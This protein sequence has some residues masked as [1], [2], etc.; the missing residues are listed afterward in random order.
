MAEAL[1]YRLSGRDGAPGLVLLH[2]LG[3]TGDLWWPQLGA[4][5]ARFRVI[6]VDL[7][8]HGGSPMP[9]RGASVS[10]FT[11]MIAALI[12]DAAPSGA[13]VAGISTGGMIAQSLAI[14]HPSLVRSLALCNTTSV[15]PQTPP[16]TADPSLFVS[17]TLVIGAA[18]R[19]RATGMATIAPIAIQRWFRPAFQ[20]REPASVARVEQMI[21][22]NQPE[23]YA[24]VCEAISRF[25]VRARLGEIR[26]PTLVIAGSHDPGTPLA[27]SLDLVASIPSA[28][29]VVI[30][31][32]AHIS[33]VERPAEFTAALTEFLD[34]RA[35]R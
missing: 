11:D 13:H 6:D 18:A 27:C 17:G 2:A 23:G 14:G 21:L 5:E 9:R 20:E 1:H 25:D 8:G 7:P 29:L 35:M 30:D 15:V 24:R 34:A 12:R 4:L 3:A 10:D 16:T 32:T 22:S 28:E 26:V 19:A 31:D 33:N